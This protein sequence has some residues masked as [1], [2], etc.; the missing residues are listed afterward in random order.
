MFANISA[1]DAL[2]LLMAFIDFV[3]LTIG[4]TERPTMQKMSK[5]ADVDERV[6]I[7]P[8]LRSPPLPASIFTFALSSFQ[9]IGLLA[10][11]SICDDY[12][13]LMLQLTGC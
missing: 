8:Q 9:I 5:P 3:K 2:Y 6:N 11:Y 4:A 7:L 13:S 10:P 1:F 12:D